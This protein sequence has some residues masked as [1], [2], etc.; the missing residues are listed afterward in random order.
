MEMETS[1]STS[2]PSQLLLLVLL[3]LLLSPSPSQAGDSKLNENKEN[4]QTL[5]AVER[6]IGITGFNSH[7]EALSSWAKLAWMNLRPPDSSGWRRSG[8]GEKMKVASKKS[9]ETSK[10]TVEKSAAAAAKAAEKAVGMTKEKIKKVVF[11]SKGDQDA[12]L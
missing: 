2:S 10:D 12:E 3:F 5:N 8:T 1:T 9:F 4:T 11:N 6:G 7:W